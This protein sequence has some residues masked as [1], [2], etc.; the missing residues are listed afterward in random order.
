MDTKVMTAHV[1]LP[2]AK[3]ID[4]LAIRLDRPRAWI[5]KQALAAWV[6]EEEERHRLTLEGMADV[7]AG[8]VVDQADV[9]AWALSLSTKP[10]WSIRQ[11]PPENW[12]QAPHTPFCCLDEC[13][14][15]RPCTCVWT[16]RRHRVCA[17]GWGSD[18][19]GHVFRFNT[20]QLGGAHR[21]RT[22]H[23][24]SSHRLDGRFV[25]RDQRFSRGHSSARRWGW[26]RDAG[27]AA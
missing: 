20:G 6:S 3:K 22:S 10:Q 23:P 27:K 9:E 13:M 19:R 4:D 1:P 16:R 18:N 26:R 14:A 25:R 17:A 24:S 11:S 21:R 15:I 7:T 12:R 2:L 8:R 5:V